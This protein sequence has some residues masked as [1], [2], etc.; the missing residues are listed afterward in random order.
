MELSAQAQSVFQQALRNSMKVKGKSSA[1]AAQPLLASLSFPAFL[2][3]VRALA[4]LV[5]VPVL[6]CHPLYHFHVEIP[7]V[8]LI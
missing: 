3:A 7:C 6:F 5:R 2:A 8:L 1:A 4:A